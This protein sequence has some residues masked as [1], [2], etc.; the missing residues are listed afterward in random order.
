VGEAL[1]NRLGPLQPTSIGVALLSDD[2]LSTIAPAAEA[3]AIA[4]RK[5]R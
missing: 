1:A 3:L 4:A 5:L 2:P